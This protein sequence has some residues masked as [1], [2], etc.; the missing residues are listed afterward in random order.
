[1]DIFPP[2]YFIQV[3]QEEEKKKKN[4]IITYECSPDDS[5]PVSKLA[6]ASSNYP[7]ITRAQALVDQV[8]EVCSEDV[9]QTQA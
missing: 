7:E 6:P 9:P 5:F 2:L 1:M 3:A 8:I 4:L